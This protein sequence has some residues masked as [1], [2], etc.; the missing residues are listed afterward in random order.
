M[1][2]GLPIDV[3][4]VP[5]P[6][7]TPV[8]DPGIIAPVVPDAVVPVPLE[9]VVPVSPEAVIPVSPEAVIPVPPEAV[10]PLGPPEAV[11]PAVG[12]GGSTIFDAVS[13]FWDS[14]HA[15]A[16]HHDN[17]LHRWFG[18]DLSI[19]KPDQYWYVVLILLLFI[20]PQ[21]FT[22]IR[23]PSAITTLGLGVVSGMVL[24]LF[25]GD[26][27]VD[28]L[29]LFGIVSLFLFAG[30]EVDFYELRQHKKVLSVH[31]AVCLSAL[32]GVASAI[33]WYFHM[34]V[35]PALIIALALLTPS[36]GFILSSLRSFGLTDAESFQVKVNAIASELLALIVLFFC[37]QSGD[38][39]TLLIASAAVVGLLIALP[40]ALWFYARYIV[41]YAPRSEFAFVMILAILASL[42]TKKLGAYYL[43]GA[44]ITG[45]V[46][47]RCKRMLPDLGS[48][49]V[50]H[51]IEL[52]ASFFIPFYF[53]H[54][55]MGL[56]AEYFSFDGLMWGGIFLAIILP[57][58]VAYVIGHRL[59]LARESFRI[60]NRIAVTLLPTLVFTLVLSGLLQEEYGAVVRERPWII[61]AL[62]IYTLVNTLLPGLFLSNGSE[63]LE[64]AHLQLTQ[65]FGHDEEMSK[66]DRRKTPGGP[67]PIPALE[68]KALERKQTPGE[69]GSRPP[70]AAGAGA[71]GSASGS[72]P[73]VPPA[74]SLVAPVAPPVAPVATPAAPKSPPPR[75]PPSVTKSGEHL[76][77]PIDTTPHGTPVDHEDESV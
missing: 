14:L 53:F 10:V 3:P 35:Q 26:D 27:T 25:H 6:V 48:K 7:F 50:V 11:D 46:A 22:R 73:S 16:A 59:P 42:L 70:F 13:S 32:A 5:D 51:S 64:F 24:G 12:S 69:S 40:I 62:I 34:P 41:R 28:L 44:F 36:T 54:A 60:S 65:R 74:P 8:V 45:V 66:K 76:P 63:Q 15:G 4:V 9:A 21:I 17:L 67:K 38:T 56:R 47:M 77:H 33:V 1:A 57:F 30:M 71:P 58:R 39:K 68:Q 72:A 23:I 55:G 20:L 29:S 43:L 31:L 18:V 49:D 37:V 19:L 75:L 61:G 52:F 2:E